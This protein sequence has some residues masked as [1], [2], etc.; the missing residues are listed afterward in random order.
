MV[1]SN[2]PVHLGST[3]TGRVSA[4]VCFPKSKFVE[5]SIG[6]PA[7]YFVL[8]RTVSD[9]SSK[10]IW[11]NKQVCIV[12]LENGKLD[13]A[14]IQPELYNKAKKFSDKVQMFSFDR[15]QFWFQIFHL[16][17]KGEEHLAQDVDN[18][19]SF[20]PLEETQA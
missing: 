8:M 5:D 4:A 6:K 14:V 19:G 20:S 13:K 16:N 7:M 1:F 10:R 17:E 9:K 12:D 15:D 3:Y 11:A 18:V 2:F